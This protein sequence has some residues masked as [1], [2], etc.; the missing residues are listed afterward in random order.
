[1]DEKI[2]DLEIADVF[3]LQQHKLSYISDEKWKVVN[4]ITSC[5]TAKLGAHVFECDYCKHK[6]ISYNS[7][8]DRHC[9]KCQSLAKMRW[10][11]K[12]DLELLPVHY[13]HLVFTIPDV[14]KGII[15]QNKR[16]AYELLF[17][18]AAETIKQ[19]ASNPDNLGALTGFFA[20]LHTWEQKLKFHPH[21][22]CVIPGG[23]FSADKTR[24]IKARK[25]Y[26]VSVKRLSLVF[27]GKFLSFLENAFANKELT[28]NAGNNFKQILIKSTT[29]NWV[30]YAKPPFN[31]P[32]W[33]VRYLSRYTHRIAISNKRLV[34]MTEESITF[35]WK[36]RRKGYVTKLET[37]DVVRFMKRFLNHVLPKGFVKIRYYGFMGNAHRKDNI[38]LIRQLLG[39][40]QKIEKVIPNNWKDILLLFTGE[41]PTIC[42]ECGKG[43]LILIYRDFRLKKAG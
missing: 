29:N 11:L 30:V 7:C 16:V 2:A 38:Y 40:K 1:M 39:V 12:R 14:L 31:G 32:F 21:I 33:V 42:T 19:V 22:H 41:D 20:I 37:I 25:N 4:A 8:R 3:R 6:E 43:H 27:R 23:G 26:F 9:P 17:K 36:D 24:W 34:S 28:L 13:F 5:R 35:T 18:A 15:I 10:I